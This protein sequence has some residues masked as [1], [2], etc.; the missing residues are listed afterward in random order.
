MRKGQLLL[1]ALLGGVALGGAMP[2]Y[3][4]E[5]ALKREPVGTGAERAL[6][7]LH[8]SMGQVAEARERDATIPGH[9]EGTNRATQKY[10]DK[11]QERINAGKHLTDGEWHDYEEH[12]IGGGLPTEDEPPY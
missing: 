4:A 2:A 10:F 8:D 9:W 3:E 1:T 11:L 6:Q 7:A 12:V 5:A